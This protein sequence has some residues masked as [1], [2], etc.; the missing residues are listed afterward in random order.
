VTVTGVGSGTAVGITIGFASFFA[1]H[2]NVMHRFLGAGATTG[3]TFGEVLRISGTGAT[4][5]G[6]TLAIRVVGGRI[7]FDAKE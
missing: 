5:L 6:S 4:S 1:S 2:M 7:A 3:S